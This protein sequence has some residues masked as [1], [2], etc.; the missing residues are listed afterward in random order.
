MCAAFFH[1]GLSPLCGGG[2]LRCRSKNL[3]LSPLEVLGRCLSA[4][5]V[6][7]FRSPFFR[8]LPR[9]RPPPGAVP[10]QTPRGLWHKPAYAGRCGGYSRSLRSLKCG[11]EPTVPP[12]NAPLPDRSRKSFP[13]VAKELL[14]ARR[15]SPTNAPW[16]MA[17]AACKASR[18]L[19]AGFRFAQMW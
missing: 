7:I 18:R 9:N 3:L 4:C 19:R 1:R 12:T 11:R 6:F 8:G 16:P 15:G 5:R 17:T 2:F 14:A 10:P 13:R